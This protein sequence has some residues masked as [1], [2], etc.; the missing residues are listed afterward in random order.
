MALLT[1]AVVRYRQT[2]TSF[3]GR[4]G[5]GEVDAT[6]CTWMLGKTIS[7]VC[8]PVTVYLEYLCASYFLSTELCRLCSGDCSHNGLG[9]GLCRMRSRESEGAGRKDGQYDEAFEGTCF[10][11]L[12]A[13]AKVHPTLSTYIL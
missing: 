8:T 10:E 1:A 11:N 6:L 7:V 2:L 4:P 5:F 9:L 13:M 12:V 3:G